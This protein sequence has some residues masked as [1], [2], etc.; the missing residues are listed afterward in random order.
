MARLRQK[1]SLLGEKADFPG[2][3]LLRQDAKLQA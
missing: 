2:L 1:I 3:P